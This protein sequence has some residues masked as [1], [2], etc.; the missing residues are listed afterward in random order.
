LIWYFLLIFLPLAPGGEPYLQDVGPFK[1]E[2]E[3][4]V[5]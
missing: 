4:E 5:H 2:R 3:C 1:S